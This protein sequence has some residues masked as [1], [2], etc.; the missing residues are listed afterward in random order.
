[1]LR[2]F[3][4]LASIPL[5]AY[6]AASTKLDIGDPAPVLKPAKWIKNAPVP[7]FRKGRVYVVEFWATW[8]NPC[9]EAIPHLTELAKRFKND[10]DIIGVDVN[11]S[12]DPKAKTL[13]KVEGFVRTMGARMDYHI[14]AD[15]PD[16]AANDAWLKA[17]GEDGIPTAFVVGKDGRIAYVAHAPAE[18]AAVLPKVI[19][20]TF[21]VAAARS[22]RALKMGPMSGVQ[23]ALAA[24]DYPLAVRLADA[25]IAKE[26][27]SERMFD[28]PLFDAL[29]H[30][31][32]A[33]FQKRSREYLARTPETF[34]VTNMLTAILAVE[35]GLPAETYRFGLVLTEEGVKL[36]QEEALFYA[37][38]TAINE[39]L[40]DKPAAVLSAE[41]AVKASEADSRWTE[42]FRARMRK[43]LA[44]VRAAA[45]A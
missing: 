7:S 29:A 31:D 26:P 2:P 42:E 12:E 43:R 4:L 16:R 40:G 34:R 14:A 38:A 27:A 32:S 45:G 13:P 20:G 28:Y 5:A 30:G 25:Q 37:I 21:D 36:K 9:K 8:C 23:N 33:T 22:A 6:A 39:N 15:G 44:E 10:V 17:A 24:K 35:K 18:L 41:A 11:E 19:D 1:M 3:A